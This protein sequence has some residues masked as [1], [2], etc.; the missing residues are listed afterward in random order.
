MTRTIASRL[1]AAS[2]FVAAVACNSGPPAIKNLKMA[3][4]KDGT[5]AT[6]TF[7]AKDTIFAVANLDNP[8]ANGKV[9]CHVNIVD[10]AG[11]KPGPIPNLDTTLNLTKG[12]NIVNF[13]FTPPPS[14]WPDGKYQFQLVLADDKGAQKDTKSADFATAGNT[15]SAAPAT[16]TD[17]A[18][19]ATDTTATDTAATDSSKQ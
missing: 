1:L 19:A 8:P 5:K 2:L 14:G 18:A 6:S 13:N 10:V 4:D 7:D 16:A 12:E 3:K 15:A 17:T 11:M 9:T